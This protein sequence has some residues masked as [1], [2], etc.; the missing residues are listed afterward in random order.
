MTSSTT[1]Y[2]GAALPSIFGKKTAAVQ[3]GLSFREW[4]SV[5]SSALAMANTLPTSG[6]V[7]AK[8]VARV[9]AMAEEL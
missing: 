4:L 1:T 7:G 8:Q 5:F 9:R 3:S 2:S 6:H